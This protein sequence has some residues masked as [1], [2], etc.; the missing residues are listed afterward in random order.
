MTKVADFHE[1]VQNNWRETV[2]KESG[3]AAP[4]QMFWETAL[5]DGV[6]S[7]SWLYNQCLH[8]AKAQELQRSLVKSVICLP[9]QNLP[10][11]I[12][13]L[14]FTRTSSCLGRLAAALIIAWLQELP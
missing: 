6:Y 9:F 3:S 8:R 4:F 2:Y 1:F 5:R 7:T 13:K 12:L 10:V 11:K 14:R